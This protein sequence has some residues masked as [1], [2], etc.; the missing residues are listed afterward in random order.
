MIEVERISKADWAAMASAAHLICFSEK[1]PAEAERVDFV[2]LA[3]ESKKTPLGYFSCKEVSDTWVYV[4]YGGAFPSALGSSLSYKAYVKGIDWLRQ[5]YS[6]ATTLIENTN[7]VMLK[8][9]L[10]MGWKIIGTKTFNG[11]IMVE[12]L[13]EFKCV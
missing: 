5:R 13:L 10:K 11:H 3:T 2:I 9:A 8:I 12:H 4:Q 6:C 7:V 1:L